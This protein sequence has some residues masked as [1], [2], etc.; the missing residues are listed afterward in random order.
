FLMAL[1]LLHERR[2][3]LEGDEQQLSAAALVLKKMHDLEPADPRAKQILARLLATQ[4]SRGD[5]VNPSR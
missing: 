1:A 4:Q 2:Y 5:A 3:E